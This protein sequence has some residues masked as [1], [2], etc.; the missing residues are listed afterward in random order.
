MTLEEIHEEWLK[1]SMEE[2]DAM[3]GEPEGFH[4]CEDYFVWELIRRI[5]EGLVPD[6]QAT[7]AKVVDWY[8]SDA[9]RWYA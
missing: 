9:E 7:C 2:V 4:G 6:P 5:S 3:K 1:G 8:D